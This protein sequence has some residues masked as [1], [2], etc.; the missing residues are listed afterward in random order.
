MDIAVVVGS[1][2]SSAKH[3]AYEG[4]KQ[5]L[6]QRVNL[7]REPIGHPTIAIDYVGAGA[8]DTVI[9]AAA[10]GLASVVFHI[11]VAPIQ[12][13]VM[14]IIDRVEAK[15]HAEFGNSVPVSS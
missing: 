5:M 11:D 6:V 3:P 15:G 2:W 1:V 13:M 7:D 14:G 12:T 9:I 8:G 4:R 10:P